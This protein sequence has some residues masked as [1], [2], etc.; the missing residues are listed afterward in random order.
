M[1]LNINFFAA[2]QYRMMQ[3]AF[4]VTGV[5]NLKTLKGTVKAPSSTNS[6]GYLANATKTPDKT[7]LVAMGECTVIPCIDENE[8]DYHDTTP[9]ANN[10]V[11]YSSDIDTTD[12]IYISR[13]AGNYR[14][15]GVIFS[16]A[17]TNK[18]SSPFTVNTLM[19]TGF[20]NSSS[21]TL[22]TISPDWSDN[23]TGND[24]LC[25]LGVIK[26][27]QPV[28]LQPN[29]SKNF[30]YAI[31]GLQYCIPNGKTNYLNDASSV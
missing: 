12:C 6:G 20:L 14:N 17:V 26:L 5:I 15:N 31:K 28:T 16:S 10:I 8:I 22:T 30:S 23:A 29:E 24:N 27:S 4:G 19:L 7:K 2:M 25:M 21:A 18:T 9:K 13:D 11:T 1:T 3:N